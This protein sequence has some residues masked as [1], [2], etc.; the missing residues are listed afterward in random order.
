MVNV[1][2]VALT[3]E[4][5]IR[6]VTAEVTQ[7]LVAW[8]ESGAQLLGLPELRLYSYSF[9]LRY[10]VMTAR[11]EQVVLV[12]I[13][14]KPAMKTLAEAISTEWLREPT[15]AEYQ[16]AQATWR[17]FAQANDPRCIAVKPLDYLE[18]WNA[19]VMLEL[20]VRPMKKFLYSRRVLLAG[21]KV[22]P[23]VEDAVRSAGKWLRI[24]HEGVGNPHPGQIS[25]VETRREIN[26]R[27]EKLKENS[28][29]QVNVDRFRES[30][31][32]LLY[33][34]KDQVLPFSILHEDYQWS[35]IMVAADGRVCG[36]DPRHHTLGPVYSDLA[37]F[38]ID[39]ETRFVNIV[40]GW[41]VYSHR[42]RDHY[43][44]V[45]VEAYFG[46]DVFEPAA[47]NF[48]CAL[49]AL[50]KWSVDEASYHTTRGG[51]WL[52]TVLSRSLSRIH[53]TRVIRNYLNG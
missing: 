2:G 8:L 12:K 4:E 20:D 50:H 26:A 49:A 11:G 44:K 29:G 19:I 52:L 43:R 33:K 35:N 46:K 37:T 6:Q 31:M 5:I 38:L 39:P 9:F 7:R 36:L 42:Q 53:F 22:L 51:K 23:E 32:E 47:L 1:Q 27:L 3:N 10:R 25:Q 15:L 17:A 45:F 41:L 21:G 40:A 28:N 30:F 16:V 18:A 34:I 14:R 24:F 48:Y 13:P